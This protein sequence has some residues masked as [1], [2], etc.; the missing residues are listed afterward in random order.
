MS[1]VTLYT[2]SAKLQG[3]KLQDAIPTGVVWHLGPS[4]VYRGT[5]H[6]RIDSDKN[7]AS[8]MDSCS[9]I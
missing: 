6:M 5:S 3:A 8:W 1:E 9:W 7:E 2:M 4:P